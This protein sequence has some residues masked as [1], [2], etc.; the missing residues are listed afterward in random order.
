[1]EVQSFFQLF[2]LGIPFPD[3]VSVVNVASKS[4]VQESGIGVTGWSVQW[5]WSVSI[6]LRFL[7]SQM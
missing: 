1:M 6:G 4:S 7:R 3:S 2:S 5:W